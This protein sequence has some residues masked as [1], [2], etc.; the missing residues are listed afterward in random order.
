MSRS[1]RRPRRGL[2]FVISS[3]S[4]AGKTSLCARLVADN[5]ALSLSVSVTTRAPRIAEENGREYHFVEPGQFDALIAG[6]ELLEWAEVHGNRYGSA[7]A[8]SLAALERGDDVLFDIDWQ[9]AAAI[10]RQAPADTVGVFILPPTMSE[11]SRRLHGRAMDTE[12]VIA[13][14]LA[15]AKREISRWLD[16]DYVLI[17]DDL[18]A[19]YRQLSSIYQAERAR[20]ARNPWL[21]SFVE[22]LLEGA[23]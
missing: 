6:D 3:P 23:G 18:E 20:R 13:R 15:G 5:P 2:L 7:R 14:R 22:D 16:Y 10:R 1:G 12:A 19:A 4:G 21:E 11:L 8:P 9:G 17:N